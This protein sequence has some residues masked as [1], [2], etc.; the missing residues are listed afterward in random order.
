MQ[1]YNALWNAANQ[2]KLAE[3]MQSILGRTLLKH[4]ETRWNSLFYLSSQIN[5]IKEKPLN[6]IV[7]FT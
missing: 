5:K 2:L 6:L 1:K 3:I 4:G 7:Y